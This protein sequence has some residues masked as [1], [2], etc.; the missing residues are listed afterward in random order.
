MKAVCWERE[1]CIEGEGEHDKRG[2]TGVH[3]PRD[4][5]KTSWNALC[6]ARRVIMRIFSSQKQG[7]RSV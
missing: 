1:G 3:W 2:S 4:H 5:I 6:I 7:E